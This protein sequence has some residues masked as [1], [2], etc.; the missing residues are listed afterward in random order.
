V[1]RKV[2]FMFSGQGSHY[3]GMGRELFESQPVFRDTLRSL[4]AMFR[5]L[6]SPGVLDEIYRSDR[7]ASDSFDLLRFT[8]PAILML[9]LALLELLRS[10]GIEPDCVLGASLGE[11]AAA[12]AAGVLTREEVARSIAEQVKLVE[13]HCPPGAMLA[14]LGDPEMFESE[15]VLRQNSELAA[16]NS[17]HHFVVTG[18]AAGLSRIGEALSGRKVLH[19]KLPVSYAF[20]SSRMEA[21]AGPYRRY[22][23]T[24]PT[25]QPELPFVSC[26]TA[27]VLAAFEAEHLWRMVRAPIRFRSTIRTLEQDGEGWLYVDLGPSG[28]LASFARQNCS[29]GSPSAAVSVL[30][31]FAPGGRGLEKVRQALQQHTGGRSSHGLTKRSETV[32]AILFPGQGSQSRGMGAELFDEFP[33]LTAQA[34]EILGYSTARLCRED[35]ERQLD[36]TQFTQPALFVVNALS[37]LSRVK[38]GSNGAAFFAGHSLGEYNALFAAGAFDFET[39][40]RLVKKRAELM[41]QV[42]DGGMAAVVG[43]DESQVRSVLADQGLD[44]IDVANYNGA[45]QHILSGPRDAVARAE[46]AFIAAGAKAYLHLR[47]SG[48][49]HSRYMEPA[50]REL[51]QFLAGFSFR[52]LKVP[53]IA[54]VTGRPYEDGTIQHSLADQL[55]HPVRWDRT[56][57]FLLD[58]GA[59]LEEVGPGNVLSKLLAK[60]RQAAPAANGNGNGNGHGAAKANGN[61]NGHGPSVPLST[62]PVVS[63]GLSPGALGSAAFRQAYGTRYAYVCGAMYRGIAS[64]DLVVRAAR[65][66]ILAFY[67]TGGLEPARLEEGI[68]RIQSELPNGEPYGMNLV[69]NPTVRAVEESTVDLFLAHGIRNLEA[70]AFMQVTPALVRYRLKGLRRGA[71][72]G[73]EIGNRIMA[74]I[75]RPEVAEAFLSPAPEAIVRRLQAEGRV[76]AEEARLAAEV[77]MADDLCIEADSGGHTDQGN[78]VVLLPTLLRLRDRFQEKHRYRTGV[79]VGA[80][81]GIGTPEAAAAAFILGAGFVLTGSINLCTVESG[82]SSTVKDMLEQMNIQDTDY[83]PAGDMFELG[84]KVQV[85]KRGVFFPARAKKLYELYRRHESLDEIDPATRAQIEQRYF[86]KTFDEVYRETR[87]YFLQKD[88]REIEKAEENPRHKMALVFRW[89]FGYSQRAAMEGREDA[90]VDFQVHCGPALGAFN[91]WVKGTP[92]E[93]WKNRHVDDIAERLMGATAAY[94]S[95][96]MTEVAG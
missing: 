28:T 25:R 55:I 60:I 77:P 93:S 95:Q 9:E 70:S 31:P 32:K 30:D 35:P 81:G 42:K 11:F 1:A 17:D 59:E 79:R 72:G 51:E 45:N 89:Y 49:F 19:Q 91:Q 15:P 27:G 3:Y 44:E 6:G 2:V 87:E 96:R 61:G 69:H 78:L 62:L 21:A 50:R 68:R 52:P 40:L 37:Y 94:L 64:V 5:D 12:T 83:A 57:H 33:D 90:R 76:T 82:M 20:H 54:N 75:S 39:G 86:R 26:E 84:A 41:A 73:V 13:E 92:L 63:A 80:A 10:E 48:A 4:D 46:P 74:K 23:A 16:I 7:T 18:A 47:V 53:V 36:Q 34:D 66:G 24:L 8:H 29:P 58:R 85:M 14:I 71:Q 56:V 65:A 67:G 88:P 43:L 38:G 22:L